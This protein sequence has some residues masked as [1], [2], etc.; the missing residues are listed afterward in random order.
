MEGTQRYLAVDIGGTVVKYSIFNKCYEELEQ[1]E[2]PTQKDPGRFLEQLFSIADRYCG[3]VAGAGICMAGFI[4]P[5]TGENTDF[6]VGE[7]FRAWN[8]KKELWEK[9]KVPVV[10]EN[11]SNCAALGE[12]TAGAGKGLKNFV[13]LTIGT[14]VGGALILDGRLVRGSHFKAGEA[15]FMLLG[16]EQPYVQAEATSV[17]VRKVSESVGRQVDGHY[18]FSHLGDPE[19]EAIY[20]NWLER[21]VLAAGNLAVLTDPEAVLIGGGGC[22]QERFISDLRERLYTFFPHLQNYT[23]LEACRTGNLAGRIGALSLLFEEMGI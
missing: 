12:L 22:R 21:I 23:R 15:G 3:Q 2:E 6:S 16:T 1:G 11:D 20:K 10:L 9:M 18:V 14:G 4:D 17:L 8:L 13:L 19:T 7:N 5:V